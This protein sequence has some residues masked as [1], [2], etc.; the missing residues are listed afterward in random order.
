MMSAVADVAAAGWGLTA[1][2][3]L[4]SA[5]FKRLQLFQ[6]AVTAQWAAGLSARPSVGDND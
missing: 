4:L 2:T 5:S 6:S 1:P 3:Q